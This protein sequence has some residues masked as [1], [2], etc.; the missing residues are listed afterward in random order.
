[1][2]RG[3]ARGVR[4]ERAETASNDLDTRREWLRYT[5]SLAVVNV[6]EG[7]ERRRPRREG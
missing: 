5:G 4:F 6:S 1:M 2:S 7:R 3:L